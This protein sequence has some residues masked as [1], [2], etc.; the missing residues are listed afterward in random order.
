[1][2]KAKKAVILTRVSSKDQ[3]SGNPI[4]AQITRLEK[5]CSKKNLEIIKT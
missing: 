1:M 4:D 2:S 5:Y 3:E